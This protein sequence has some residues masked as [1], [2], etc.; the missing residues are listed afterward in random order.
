L[1]L[2]ELEVHGLKRSNPDKVFRIVK[3]DGRNMLVPA[4]NALDIVIRHSL[5][6]KPNIQDLLELLFRG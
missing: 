2:D 5:Q 3:K 4:S 6:Q 1:P